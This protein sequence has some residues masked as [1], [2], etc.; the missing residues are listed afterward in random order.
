MSQSGANMP[1]GNR[2]GGG[3]VLQLTRVFGSTGGIETCVRRL[4][5]DLVSR[6]V[7][8]RVLVPSRSQGIDTTSDAVSVGIT[9]F[10][11]MDELSD[12]VRNYG[13]DLVVLHHV[14]DGRVTDAV[15]SLYP[16]IEVVHTMLCAGSK[17]FRRGDRLCGH[18]VG[19]RCLV[20]WYAGPCGTSPSPLVAARAL[21]SARAYIGGLQRL[22]AVVVGSTYMRDYLQVEGIHPRRIIVA[23]LGGHRRPMAASRNTAHSNT[24]DLSVLFVG[25]VVY[26]KGLQYLVKAFQELDATFRLEVAGDG[27]Y[28][29]SVR[30]L[31]DKV[32]PAG[33]VRFLGNLTGRDLDLVY[34]E[35]DVV[36]VP[37][38]CPEPVGLVVGEARRHGVPVVV[39]DA[40]GLPEWADGDPG[41]VV[42][43]R[44][45]ASAL[46]L[47]LR[48][49]SRSTHAA[50]VSGCRG[51]DSLSDVVVNSIPTATSRR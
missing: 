1:E 17:L 23:D 49:L 27:W 48:T 13:P 12:A 35:A 18:P 10:A 33:R 19:A 34:S 28:A 24:G 8:T 22:D 30:A 7:D 15:R 25:R 51:R 2:V 39:S 40:G 26:N 45:S 36:V 3:R 16:T 37:S 5:A 32:Q 9:S 47:A 43:P 42:V 21:R 6:G 44:A 38:L 29:P 11:Q 20:D 50:D 14:G 41:V 46:A 4:S 31:A